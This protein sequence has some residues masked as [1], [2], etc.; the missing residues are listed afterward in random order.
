MDSI[1]TQDT[2]PAIERQG[3]GPGVSA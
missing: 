3:A 2:G 1:D